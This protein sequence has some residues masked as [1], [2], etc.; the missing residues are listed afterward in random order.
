MIRETYESY[1]TDCNDEDEDII[2]PRNIVFDATEKDGDI[3][4]V[5]DGKDG[6]IRYGSN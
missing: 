6:F 3:V 4:D 5:V 2:S 1:V